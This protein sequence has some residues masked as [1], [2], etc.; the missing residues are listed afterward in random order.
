MKLFF[1]ALFFHLTVNIYIFWRG[2]EILRNKKVYRSLFATLYIIEFII[3]LIG[4]FFQNQLPHQV[5]HSIALMGTTW[6][7]FT[8]YMTLFLVVIDIIYFIDKRK[9]YLRERYRAKRIRA[10]L[11][12]FS[13]FFT[14]SILM[15]GNYKFYHPSVVKYDLTIHKKSPKIKSLKIVMA[16]DIHLGFLIDNSHAKR[17]VDLINAQK[18]DLILLVGD[19]IDATYSPIINRHMEGEMK[20]LHAPY[21]I[22]GCT[23]NHEYRYERE[24]KI[25]W[26]NNKAKI[27]MLRDSVALIDSSFY[28]I[29]REDRSFPDRKPYDDV[30]RKYA[31]DQR[32]PII[33]LDH[34]P[35]NLNENARLGTDL[36]LYGHTHDGQ[37]FPANIMS[38]ILYEVSRGYKLKNNTHSIVTSGLGLA[39]PQYRI[40]TQSEIV[41]INLKFT[42]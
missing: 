30:M 24:E 6:M 18:P 25:G 26:L 23:G 1:Y 37:F 42:D 29:G 33:V 15:W 20:K 27:K 5:I 11:F 41:V 10:W 7:L 9:P 38:R 32:K 2:W 31:V 8:L 13:L 17:Y 36:A 21:G 19:I 40:G 22:Y 4:L 28:I 16:G 35:M 14:I 39:G 3:Y 12:I 34:N